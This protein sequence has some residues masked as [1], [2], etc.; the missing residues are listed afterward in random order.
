MKA[1][2]RSRIPWRACYNKVL[3]PSPE[4]LIPWV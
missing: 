1:A 4:V 2:E 3:G